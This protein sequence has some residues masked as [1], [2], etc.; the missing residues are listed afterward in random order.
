M[1]LDDL[2]E[3]MTPEIYQRLAT[4][5]EL[6]KWPDGVALSAEQKENCLQMVM[7]WQARHNEQAEHMTIGTNGEIVMKSKQQ[8]KQQFND[9]AAI[10]KLKPQ[11]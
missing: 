10:I 7:M 8:L 1:Q 6:G 9:D 11:Q 4:A 2:I 5:V 3:A